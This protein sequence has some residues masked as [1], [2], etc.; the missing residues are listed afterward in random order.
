MCRPARGEV[1]SPLRIQTE[2]LSVFQLSKNNKKA[3]FLGR[4]VLESDGELDST[5]LR[6][7]LDWSP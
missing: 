7:A 2:K 3:R 6:R 4:A 1:N 5:H